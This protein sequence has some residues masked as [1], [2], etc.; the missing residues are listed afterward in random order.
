MITISRLFRF[1]IVGGLTAFV[2]YF[3]LYTLVEYAMISVL[4]SSSV[5]Y[6]V[7]I[8][9]NYMLHYGW[10]FEAKGP[11]RIAMTRF[12]G[13]NVGGFMINFLIM[14]YFVSDD[15]SNYLVVQLAA[16][17][18][19]IIWNYILSSLWVYKYE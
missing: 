6:I 14:Y 13:M 19:I 3:V 15:N 18:C 12:I 5:A 7:A 17:S 10:T 1:S 4:I 2:F 8:V 16:I 11:H 9:L